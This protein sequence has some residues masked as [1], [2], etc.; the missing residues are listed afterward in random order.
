MIHRSA[1]ENGIATIRHV[2]GID[3]A[4]GAEVSFAPGG[5]HVMLMGLKKPLKQGEHFTLTLTLERAG[6]MKVDVPVAG[7]AGG[8]PEESPT[9]LTT[10]C[11]FGSKPT[12]TALTSGA[13]P[14]DH[15]FAM[16]RIEAG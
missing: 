7:V 4:P 10:P 1:I 15:S 13:T 3:I 8:A 12:E 2:E 9:R 11:C 5:T 14:P 6:D 16:D